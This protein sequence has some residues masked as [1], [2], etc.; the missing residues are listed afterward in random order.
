VIKR[1]IKVRRDGLNRNTEL[2]KTST[3]NFYIDDEEKPLIFDDIQ[4]EADE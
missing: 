1:V 2:V 3:T 4:G